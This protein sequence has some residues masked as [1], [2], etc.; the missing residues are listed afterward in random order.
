MSNQNFEID[1][2][3]LNIVTNDSLAQTTLKDL[4]FKVNLE[5]LTDKNFL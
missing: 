5:F 1:E 2:F 4:R 3:R